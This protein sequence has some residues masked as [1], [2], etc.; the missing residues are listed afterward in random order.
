[1]S[2]LL[3]DNIEKPR[4]PAHLATAISS[5]MVIEQRAYERGFKL[6]RAG[7]KEAHDA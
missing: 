4:I 7:V 5:V 2:A 1:M 6:G 3:D